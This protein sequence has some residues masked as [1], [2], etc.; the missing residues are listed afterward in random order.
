MKIELLR[1]IQNTLIGGRSGEMAFIYNSP[2]VRELF[3]EFES[4]KGENEKFI[5]FLSSALNYE[6][7]E[8]QNNSFFVSISIEKAKEYTKEENYKALKEAQ[9]KL[10][11][12]TAEFNRLAKIVA[13]D[14]NNSPISSIFEFSSGDKIYFN[15]VKKEFQGKLDKYSLLND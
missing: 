3:D 8:K 5:D 1:I 13:K 14:L 10:N 11:A 2:L 12:V 9:E 4:T 7:E 15:T 6:I